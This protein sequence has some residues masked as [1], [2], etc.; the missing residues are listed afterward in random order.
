MQQAELALS[1]QAFAR[2]KARVQA[3]A[4]IA[5]SG[6]KRTLVISRLSRL[7][8]DSGNDSFESYLDHLDN[9]RDPGPAQAFINALTTNLTRFWREEHHYEHLSAYVGRLLQQPRPGDKRLRLWSA[10]CSTGQEAYCMALTLLDAY[11]ELKRWDFRILATDIDTNVLERATEGRYPA[12]ELGG[13]SAARLRLFEREADGQVRI[14][15]AARSVV[16]F[17]HLNLMRD[18]WPMRGPFDAIFCRNVAIYFDRST[19]A[20]LFERLGRVLVPG[21]FLY[22][23][24]SESIGAGT[25]GLELCGKTTYQAKRQARDAA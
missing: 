23:G 24:H 1:E 2:V 13:L 14:P 10:G 16:A 3:M 6:A 21:G 7:V 4:G 17:R 18:P 22:I 25:A 12:G 5:L 9:A 8:W 19:Q 15:A 20:R 11:P